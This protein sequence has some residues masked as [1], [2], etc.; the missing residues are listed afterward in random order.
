M[1]ERPILYSAPM[2]RARNAGIKRM[3]RRVIKLP[4]WIPDPDAAI[5]HLREQCAVGKHAGLALFDD[6]R[7]VKRFTCPFGGPGDRLRGKENAWVWCRKERDGDTKTGRPKYNYIPV[8]K[9]V[10]YQAECPKKP[11]LWRDENPAHDWRLK[12]GRYLPAW[13]SRILDEITEVRVERVQAIS[14]EDARAEGIE[15]LPDASFRGPPSA[16]GCTVYVTARAAFRALWIHINGQESW[17]RND[18]C[19]VI[20]FKPVSP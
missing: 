8:G 7:P 15:P 10:V 3:T 20:S 16:E 2:A 11:T 17:D 12:I 1:N 9:H 6:G 5:Y 14:E 18:W 13:A 4:S 19:W